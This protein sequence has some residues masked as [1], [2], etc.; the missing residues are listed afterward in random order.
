MDWSAAFPTSEPDVSN[1]ER[2]LVCLRK[3]SFGRAEARYD[4][5]ASPLLFFRTPGFELP[6]EEMYGFPPSSR[7]SRGSQDGDGNVKAAPVPKRRSHR[8]YPPAVS[9]LRLPKARIDIGETF[10]M[11]EQ[12]RE[13]AELMQ[14]SVDVH[15]REEFGRK[16]QKRRVEVVEREGEGLWGEKEYAEIGVWFGEA[17]RS[18]Q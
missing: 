14:R 15:E 8:K 7:R 17:L 3:A 2:E 9:G 13:M 12:A 6:P 18:R 10:L 4:P 11:K 1:I 5:F 16:D